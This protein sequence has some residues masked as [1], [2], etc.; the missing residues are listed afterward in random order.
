MG[1][2]VKDSVAPADGAAASGRHRSTL[3][4]L[5]PRFNLEQLNFGQRSSPLLAAGHADNGGK[6]RRGLAPYAQRLRANLQTQV[7][8]GSGRQT[9]GL[10]GFTF[11]PA[12][13][14][15]GGAA[16]RRALCSVSTG[17]G[18]RAGRDR[19]RRKTSAQGGGW[20]RR[21]RKAPRAPVGRSA[22]WEVTPNLCLSSPRY[23]PSRHWFLMEAQQ[24]PLAVLSREAHGSA[25][26]PPPGNR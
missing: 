22:L 9:P 21:V 2:C 19:R 4:A 16:P 25:E 11:G 18:G 26:S 14:P 12:T 6:T 17:G 20:W 24:R 8:R 7:C 5:P 23:L 10:T 3:C 1:W 13:L 15:E